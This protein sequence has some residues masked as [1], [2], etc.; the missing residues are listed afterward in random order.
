MTESKGMIVA[1]SKPM[2]TQEIE[3]MR[4]EGH[5]LF[6]CDLLAFDDVRN[7]LTRRLGNKMPSRPQVTEALKAIGAVPLGQIRLGGN[8][9]ARLWAWRNV[10]KWCDASPEEMRM[11]HV[12]II[13]PK[14]THGMAAWVN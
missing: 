5:Y 6:L 8:A 9:R 1:S 2:C 14:S 7:E 10:E 4:D 13:P 11:T 12:R 3:A